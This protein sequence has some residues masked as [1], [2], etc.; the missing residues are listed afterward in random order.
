[1]V[2]LLDKSPPN[3][4][5]APS[6]QD[7]KGMKG[8]GTQRPH[9]AG[10]YDPSTAPNTTEFRAGTQDPSPPYTQVLP[11]AGYRGM[12]GQGVEATD[13]DQPGVLLGGDG[14]QSPQK[15]PGISCQAEE[16]VTSFGR[17]HKPLPL[18]PRE[19]VCSGNMVGPAYRNTG[20]HL[21]IE[22]G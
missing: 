6:G 13:E 8:R 3:C 16:E 9:R 5:A 14:C 21:F 17:C 11:H 15:W 22:V 20:S 12:G 2:G 7:G 18:G 1:M 10:S 4:P 19:A